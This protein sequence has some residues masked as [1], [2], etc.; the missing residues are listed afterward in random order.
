MPSFCALSWLLTAS[1][2][3]RELEEASVT[4][5]EQVSSAVIEDSQ[6]SSYIEKLEERYDSAEL[7]NI[8]I[9][10]PDEV[11]RDLEDFLK[12]RQRRSGGGTFDD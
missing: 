6:L 4:Y 8:E 5:H 1:L 2:E 3:L 9:P 7:R 10:Q 11:L 12:E